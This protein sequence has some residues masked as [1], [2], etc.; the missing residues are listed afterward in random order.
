MHGLRTAGTEEELSKLNFANKINALLTNR[1]IIVVFLFALVIAFSVPFLSKPAVQKLPTP[2]ESILDAGEVMFLTRNNAHCYYIYRGEPMGFEYDLAGAFADYLGVKLKITIAEEWEKMIPSLKEGSGHIIAASLTVT[3]K[4]LAQVAF[5]DGYMTIQQHVII[6][7]DNHN[8]KDIDDLSGKTIH[9]RK[10]TSYHDLL[11]KMKAEGMHFDVVPVNNIPTGELIQHV[12]NGE[13]DITIADSNVAMLNRRYFPRAVIGFPIGEKEHLAWAVDPGSESLRE[14]IN[15]FFKMIK[16]NGTYKKIYARYYADVERFDFVDLRAYHRR[17]VTRLPK[18]GHIIKAAS[19]KH[20]F[21]WRLISAQMYQESHFRQWVKS[22]AGAYGLMQLTQRTAKS[23]G[24]KDI[25]N[26][27]QNIN[28]GVKHLKELY[29]LFDKAEGADRLFIA[30]AAYNVGQGHIWDAQR[31]AKKMNLDPNKW[32]SLSKTLPLLQNRKYYRNAKHGYCR[33][34]EPV[35]YV[36]QIMIYY[37]I[38]K[39]QG[40]DYNLTP[41]SIPAAAQPSGI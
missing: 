26:P 25:Y 8:I 17:L 13:I 24:V 3:P 14:E 28:A 16:K 33:G 20:G 18:Y 40:I 2:L 21:D 9:I 38:L 11:E 27:E 7:R 5:S 39:H 10:G 4:R 31:L 36:R 6:N 35:Q 23:H 30:F 32:S 41:F 22:P 37:D 12:A 29:D 15:T 34:I 19:D 1:I